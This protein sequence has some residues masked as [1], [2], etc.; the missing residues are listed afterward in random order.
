MAKALKELADT[1]RLVEW[2]EL[3]ESVKS[4]PDNFDPLAEGVLMKHQAE[5]CRIDAP[6]KGC[7]KGR[8]TGITFAEA[9][10][11]TLV[12]AARRTAGGMDVFYVPDTKDKGLE[13]I[14]YCARFARVI[15][16][17]QG[18]G[19]SGI[20]QFLFVD[21]DDKGN[22]RQITAWRIRFASGFKIVALSSRPANLRGLQGKVVIDEAAFHL[23]VQEVLDAAT[24]LQIWGGR[25]VVISSHK[26]KKNPFNQFIRDIEAGLYGPS[27]D[28]A[29]LTV[30]FDD[31]VKNGLY[32]RVC[33]VTRETPS[34]EGKKRWYK[35]IR[36]AYGPRKAAMRE[37]LDAIP[38]DG[39]GLV[40]PGVWIDAAMTDAR[41]V[42][43][44]ALDDDFA[45][46]P[47]HER[48]AW[49]ADWIERYLKP[50]L[51]QLDPERRHVFGQD[52]ARHRDFSVITPYEIGADRRRKV[53][54]VIE[55]HKVPT[56]Q[57]E[58]ILWALIDA[59]PRFGGGAMDATGSGQTLAEYTADK[60]GH[61]RIH[62]VVLN[63]S[64]YGQYMPK[65]IGGFEDGTIDLPRDDDIANDLRAIEDSDGVSMVSKVRTADLKDP[66]LYRHGDSAVALCL[67]WYAT[68]EIDKGPVVIAS[69]GRRTA[70]NFT[71][72]Y[73]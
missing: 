35:R 55:L 52:F 12:A 58:Q 14:G 42:L 73:A 69:R 60:Y 67:G 34:A 49:V 21:Q 66:D 68:L 48:R 28:A 37:E 45:A 54:F 47:D 63:R 18:Q 19:L 36:A 57:Q 2:D 29:T 39:G 8:R 40:L 27:S 62:Q 33:M 64:W 46:R 1:E 11:D 31:A 22:T 24:A 44:L 70:R 7:A 5:W 20:E 4:I 61:S 15:A 6:L 43:R 30:T 38:R 26:G 71:A 16:E 53:P 9:L 32:E 23:N 51:Q 65:F 72:G 56:R 13:F 59:L 10:D 17:A 3:P 41:P 25:I 50:L